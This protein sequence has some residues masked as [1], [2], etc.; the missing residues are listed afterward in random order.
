[1]TLKV[2]GIGLGRTGTYSLKAAL[3]ELQ[4]GPCDHMEHVAQNMSDQVPLWNA[5]LNNKTDFESVHQGM[6]SAVDWP[7]AAFYK[8]LLAKYPEAQFILTH[9]SKESWAESF[10]STI[11]KLLAG[12]ATAPQPAQ[13][14]LNTVVNVI[15]KTGFSMDLDFAGLAAQ[16]EAH[17]QAVK[18][19]IPS[20]QL[21]VYQVKQGWQSLCEFLNVA[22]PSTAFP[23]TN[24]REEF[25]ELVNSSM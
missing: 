3:E 16:F 18:N 5:V 14:W 20:E 10:G 7:T 25:W 13:D 9:R 21:L 24:N 12:R 4:F 6:Q 19:T 15:Q 8:E 22:V 2:I 17:N 11:Y 23:R 1:M